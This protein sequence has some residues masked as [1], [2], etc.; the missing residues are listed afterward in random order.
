MIYRHAFGK[1][2]QTR[3]QQYLNDVAAEKA[4][5]KATQLEPYDIIINYLNNQAEYLIL[6][7]QWN[8]LPNPFEQENLRSILPVVDVSD[9][10]YTSQKIRLLDVL[11]ILGIF[12]SEKNSSIW[13]GSF[14]TFSGSPVFE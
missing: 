14:I 4:E 13:S 6:E 8:A 10:M 7:L 1:H 2:D 11:S 9:S 5:I 3:Y 12:F